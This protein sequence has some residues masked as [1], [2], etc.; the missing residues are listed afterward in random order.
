MNRWCSSDKHN[1]RVPVAVY[2]AND[3][4]LDIQWNVQRSCWSQRNGKR[5]SLLEHTSIVEVEDV[6]LTSC[7][8]Y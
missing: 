8:D 3:N 7:I 4:M 5:R 1:L 2:V 6:Q